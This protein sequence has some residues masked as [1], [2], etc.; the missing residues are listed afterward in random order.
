MDRSLALARLALSNHH[1]VI[2]TSR[3][4]SRTPE[5]VT[6]IESL[7]G[8]FLALDVTSSSL[9]TILDDATAIY[10]HIDILVNNAG[11]A[12]LGAFETFSDADCRAQ[13]E[14]NFFA[15]LNIVRHFLP[16]MRQRKSGTIVNISSTAGIEAKA[17][18]TLYSA[19]KFALEGF[20]EA[21]YNE[22]RPLGVRVLLVEPG[23]FRSEFAGNVTTGRGEKEGEKELPVEYQGTVVQVTLDAVHK[24]AAGGD[25]KAPGSVEKGAQAIF[26]VVMGEGRGKTLKDEGWL[27]LPLGTDGSAR[28]EVKLKGLK[29]NLDATEEIW[30]STDYD[31]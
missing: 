20:S 17:S 16:A 13:M 26:D 24:M 28:W 3:N 10:G 23:A 15:P 22:M 12:L 6:E 18:R 11:Y 9:S 8:H 19:S 30:K 31:D 1:R 4:P 29:D 7:G 5:L 14:T 27:R 25:W 2:A 21:L